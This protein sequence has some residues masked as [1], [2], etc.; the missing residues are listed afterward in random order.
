MTYLTEQMSAKKG[1][2]VFGQRGIDA[3]NKE[4]TQLL[5]RNVMRPVK[6]TSLTSGQKH[7]ALKYLM[8]LKEKR[9]GEVKGRGCADGRKQRVY[10]TKEETHAPTVSHEA[11]FLTAMVDA[12]EG[13]D[14]AVVDIPGAFMQADIDE[15]INVKLEGELVDLIIRLDPTYADFVC[16][17]K[18]KR[19]IYTELEKALYG[20]L[21][22]ALLFWKKLT[23]FLIG[24]LGF[25][26]NPYDSCVVNKQINGEQF[27][28]CWHVDDLKLSHKSPQVVSNVIQELNKEFGREAPLTVK[29]GKV[30]DDYLG[31]RM[32]YSKAGKVM[33]SMEKYIDRLVGDTPTEW[34]KG[35][36]ST[37]AANHL[38]QV[39]DKVD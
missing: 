36:C 7:A 34:L 19:V 35:P 38:F 32:D 4:L 12:M 25:K 18:G 11:M 17:E 6:A 37:P 15:L 26:M 24:H 10:K 39:N 16:H 1:L 3:L 14:V 27:T 30:F 8:F 21:Q 22:A 20:T 9:S 33:F 28:I 29:R 2:R 23:D 5:Y 31:M 13:R